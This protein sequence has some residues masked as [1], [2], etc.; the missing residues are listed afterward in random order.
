MV[1]KGDS[2]PFHM[3]AG[4]GHEKKLRSDQDFDLSFTG[5]FCIFLQL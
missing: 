4:S 5:R 3:L 1:P 2:N